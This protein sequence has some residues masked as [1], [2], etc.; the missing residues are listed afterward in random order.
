MNGMAPQG[1]ISATFGCERH[2]V[3]IVDHNPREKSPRHLRN[4]EENCPRRLLRPCFPVRSAV[5][6][7]L[8]H[9]PVRPLVLRIDPRSVLLAKM[10]EP[11]RLGFTLTFA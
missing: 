3:L 11:E 8:L 1:E 2:T 5:D 10:A 9:L 7:R 6:H 4:H